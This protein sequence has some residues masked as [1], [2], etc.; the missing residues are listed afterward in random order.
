MRKPL[1]WNRVIPVIAV[2][3]TIVLTPGTARAGS[4]AQESLALGY[5]TENADLVA[6]GTLVSAEADA[7]GRNLIV[8][9]ALTESIRG[10]GKAGDS[11]VVHHPNLGHRP[12]WVEGRSH[13]LFLRRQ[14]DEK[15]FYIALVGPYSIRAIPETGD[16][17]R[18]PGIV[19]K[20]AS[21]LK[22]DD[23][24]A[25]AA[26]LR[27]L[28]VGWMEDASAGVAWSAA[29]DFIRRED[30]HEGLDDGQ[31]AR[32]LKAFAGHPYGKASKDA[33]AVAVA[34]ARPAGAGAVLVDSLLDEKG[35]SIRGTVA[36][37]LARIED[38]KVPAYIAKKLGDAKPRARADLLHVLGPI[39]GAESVAVVRKYVPDATAA[40]RL[41]AAHSLGQIARTVREDKPDA[42]VEGRTELEGMLAA[43]KT[44]H[45]MQAA[46][47]ALAQLQ[48]PDA[49]KLLERLEKE[50]SRAFVRTWAK[51]YRD[52]PR[53][54]LILR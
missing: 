16:M 54:S 35:R 48:D 34:M 30:L 36:D 47:W 43:A 52:R 50:D 24:P 2:L 21:T 46:L 14:G 31:R 10:D 45:E 39:G 28:L 33:L 27:S 51:R 1:F 41:E 37:A 19:R 17:A 26:K 7:S 23:R 6:M 44:Q 5:Q 25:D 12:P 11:V 3:A 42:V 13:L 4:W 53:L 22:T 18:M 40:V 32:I 49:V 29:L 9:F 8:T 20:I 15:V 38:P